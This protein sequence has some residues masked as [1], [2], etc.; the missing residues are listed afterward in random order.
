MRQHSGVLSWVWDSYIPALRNPTQLTTEGKR[1]RTCHSCEVRGGLCGVTQP[2]IFG[3][4]LARNKAPR[5]PGLF[6]VQ[7]LQCQRGRGL[8]PWTQLGSLY[9]QHHFCLS[10]S[11]PGEFATREGKASEP[12]WENRGR[13][14]GEG[15]SWGGGWGGEQKPCATS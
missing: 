6:S 12:L 5:E 4:T 9:S 14:E 11:A 7:E 13:C 8:P 2:I 10:L 3:M 15:R 1:L